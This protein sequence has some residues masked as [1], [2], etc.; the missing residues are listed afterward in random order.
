MSR[1]KYLISVALSG[2]LLACSP[3][4]AAQN[5]NKLETEIVETIAKTKQ[6]ET[7]RLNHFFQE[8]FQFALDRSPM[9]KSYLG[10]KDEDY[11]KWDNPS[12]EYAIESN[13]LQL[14]AF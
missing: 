9:F 8:Q 12:L 5:N 14:A 7:Q 6:T 13:N 11:G 10:I 4:E 3:E 2:L 1:S